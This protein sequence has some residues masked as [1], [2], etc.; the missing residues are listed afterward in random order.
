MLEADRRSSQSE[1]SSAGQVHRTV[2]SVTFT[3]H[4]TEASAQP[5]IFF[6][7]IILWTN[8]RLS[9]SDHSDGYLTVLNGHSLRRIYKIGQIFRIGQSDRWDGY[10]TVI[11][12]SHSS[13]NLQD[14]MVRTSSLSPL[15]A[16]SVLRTHKPTRVHKLLT[17]KDV[18]NHTQ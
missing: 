16:K 18:F 2:Q 8:L 3:N 17:R 10:S 15:L 12:R 6:G 13:E 11:L 4:K 9:Q 5:I 7:R 1:A 14:Q